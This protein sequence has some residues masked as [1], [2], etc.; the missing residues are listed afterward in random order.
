MK[1]P[2]ENIHVF[3]SPLE[4]SAAEL[5]TLDIPWQPAR[6][7]PIFEYFTK[8]LPR[9]TGDLLFLFWG[10]HGLLTTGK[11]RLIYADASEVATLN[12]DLDSLHNSLHC[13]LFAGLPRQVA[14]IDACANHVEHLQA[15]EVFPCERYE[16]GCE[17]FVLYGAK[18]GELARNNGTLKSG[19]FS[20]AVL[21]E[22]ERH[23]AGGL[24]PDFSTMAERLGSRFQ[25][26]RTAGRTDQTP[27]FYWV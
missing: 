26:L 22:L 17:Q 23:A 7:E 21:D 11:R 8:E 18:P 24:P 9:K 15:P 12:L 14:I 3:A 2:A 27:V 5:T 13:D 10:G 19:V 1:S 6:R 4:A 20:S 16:P 25:E